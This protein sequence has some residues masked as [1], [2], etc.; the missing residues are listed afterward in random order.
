MFQWRFEGPIL[1]SQK[2]STIR[3]AARCKPNDV[4]SLRRWIDKPYRSKQAIIKTAVCRKVTRLTIG[5]SSLHANFWVIRHEV[6]GPHLMNQSNL[7]NLAK[8]E[9][10][11]T[12]DDL[13]Q[14]FIDN[15]D[16]KPGIG[17][18]CE[19]IQW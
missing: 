4:L 5:I 2:R 7:E 6:D 18:E 1:S 11:D 13:R 12:V 8:I 16:L 15:R 10:F 14:W 19:Q 9:G 3:R 17:F